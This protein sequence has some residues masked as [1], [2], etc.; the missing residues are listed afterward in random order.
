M[1]AIFFLI[2]V[3]EIIRPIGP[4]NVIPVAGQSEHD[5]GQAS[6]LTT[7]QTSKQARQTID[8]GPDQRGND[9][10][11]SRQSGLSWRGFPGMPES[12]GAVLW[13]GFGGCERGLADA[14]V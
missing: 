10:K 5:L 12:V 6:N 14:G 8:A 3:E 7:N 1:R 2:Q 4:S 11:N 9:G 13:R